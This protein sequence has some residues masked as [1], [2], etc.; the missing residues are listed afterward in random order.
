MRTRTVLNAIPLWCLLLIALI[1]SNAFAHQTGKSVFIAHIK[2]DVVDTL[3]TF[4]LTDVVTHL[5]LSE[6]GEPTTKDREKITAYLSKKVRVSV[7]KQ[8][9]AT[10]EIKLGPTK[11]GTDVWFLKAFRCA[12]P[13]RATFHVEAMTESEGGY[14]HLAKIEVQ[15]EILTTVFTTGQA[16]FS[17]AKP[18]EKK[19]SASLWR[20]FQLGFTHVVIGLDHLLFLLG[21][22]LVARRL[23]ELVAL[24]TTFTVAHAI[25]ISLSSFEIVTVPPTVIEPLIALTIVAIG[26]ETARQT[27]G[28]LTAI[29]VFVLGLVHGF[30]FSY[31]LRDA[32]LPPDGALIALIGFN[33]GVEAAQIGFVAIGFAIASIIFRGREEMTVQ[34]WKTWVGGGISVVGM[35]WMIMRLLG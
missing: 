35:G 16:T 8:T 21:L 27:P 4:P 6:S 23:R 7:D 24:T 2:P 29:V 18:E 17:L 9:C 14:M 25:T 34:T 10:D 22:I 30:G 3:L 33:V 19:E 11:R 31:A 15:D 20:F 26:I 28:W 13:M 5:E 12:D 1:S 32:G